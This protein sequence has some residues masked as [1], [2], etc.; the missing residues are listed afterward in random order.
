MEGGAQTSH[1]CVPRPPHF[2]YQSQQISAS[3]LGQQSAQFFEQQYPSF[4]LHL[5]EQLPHSVPIMQ[6]NLGSQIHFQG[7][8]VL[9]SLGMGVYCNLSYRSFVVIV[10]SAKEWVIDWGF[11]AY[12]LQKG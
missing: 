8:K 1:G 9:L 4:N 7:K 10:N 11:P 5:Q 3:R 12:V 2:N 6:H